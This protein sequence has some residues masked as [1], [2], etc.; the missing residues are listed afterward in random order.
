[1]G[2]YLVSF[3]VI[4]V[5][6]LVIGVI[7]FLVNRRKKQRVALIQQLAAQRGWTYEKVSS[8]YHDGFVLRGDGWFFESVATSS[9]QSS[10]SGSTNISYSNRWVSERRISPEGMVLIGPRLP[11]VNLGGLGNLVLQ[12]AMKV[13]LGDEAGE[14]AGLTEVE[15]GRSALRER[16]S[17]WTASES[18]A[19]EVLT[20]EVEN[21][22][23][24]WELKEKPVIRVSARGTEIRLKEGRVQD[25]KDVAEVIRLGEAFLHG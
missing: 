1:M 20:F 21:E 5:T 25:P 17:V 18:A 3:I 6:A 15:V 19:V 24:N 4:I 2:D 9:R 22:L 8:T 11:S 10:Q 7:F 16:Y 23:L 12:Q 13:M 14:A